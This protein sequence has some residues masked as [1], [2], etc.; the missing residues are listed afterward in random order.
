MP[1]YRRRGSYT[2]KRNAGHE[3]ARAHVAAA[4]RL[5]TELGGADEQVKEWFFALP[6]RELSRILDIY[7]KEY[8]AS[9]RQYAEKTIPKWSSGQVQ[10]GGMVAERLFNLLPRFMP[11]SLKYK[12]TEGLWHHFGP[13]SRRTIWIGLDADIAAVR[14]LA[15][16]HFAEKASAFRIPQSME[17][18][19]NWIAADDVGVK[20]DL[21]NH[22]RDMEKQLVSDALT[23]Q[24]PVL[25]QH[26]AG[27]HGGNVT[28]ASQV[29]QV[30]K[31]ELRINIDKRVNGIQETAPRTVSS[32]GGGRWFW[33]VAG[34]G[35]VLFLVFGR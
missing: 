13:S 22:L 32:G 16:A 3:R 4:R 26:L 18:R 9:A 31:H 30:G 7:E 34:I 2:Y 8:G 11:L 35:F 29:L 14:D 28:H 1:R 23:I 21:L 19:F 25:F 10:M 6:T 33:W 15:R 5:T 12:L 24:L 17:A 27:D 20:Q